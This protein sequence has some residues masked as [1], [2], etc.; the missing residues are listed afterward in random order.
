MYCK[1]RGTL[2]ESQSSIKRTKKKIKIA[3]SSQPFPK[4]R[5]F[6]ILLKNQKNL[7]RLKRTLIQRPRLIPS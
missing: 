5:H 2:G 6:R 3:S 4:K 1:K 7:E